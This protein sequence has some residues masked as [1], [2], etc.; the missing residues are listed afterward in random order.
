VR[1]LLDESVPRPLALLLQGYEV[2]TVT[3][4]GWASVKNGELLRLAAAEGFGALVTADRSFEFQQDVA[5]SGLGLIVLVARSNKIEDIASLV[6][7]ILE[8][9]AAIQAGHV[10]RVGTVHRRRRS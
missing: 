10:V 3:Q 7:Q 8:G 4:M 9:L 5:R 6:P 1:V 2:R